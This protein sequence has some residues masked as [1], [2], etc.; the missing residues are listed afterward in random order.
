MKCKAEPRAI[1]I[2]TCWICWTRRD[3]KWKAKYDNSRV[4]CKRENEIKEV[5]NV[6]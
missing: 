3:D 2:T 6:R 4:L 5:E 1:D